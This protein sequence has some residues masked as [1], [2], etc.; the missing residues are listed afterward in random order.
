MAIEDPLAREAAV[1]AC[2]TVRVCYDGVAISKVP[3]THRRC[4]SRCDCSVPPPLPAL[5]FHALLRAVFPSAIMLTWRCCGLQGLSRPDG[6]GTMRGFSE[7]LFTGVNAEA[8]AAAERDARGKASG[9]GDALEQEEVDDHATAQ[10]KLASH[11]YLWYVESLDKDV[12]S[13]IGRIELKV[14]D[15]RSIIYDRL[16]HVA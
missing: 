5:D 3:L 11:S 12:V 13:G 10:C 4:R 8:Q 1:F 16:R 2:T 6:G 15:L 14:R 9:L 7:G